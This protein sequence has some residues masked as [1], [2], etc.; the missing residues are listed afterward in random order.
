[1]SE[2]KTLTRRQLD[3]IRELI[4]PGTP[5]RGTPCRVCGFYAW[6]A[7]ATECPVWRG[8]TVRAQN[9]RRAIREILRQGI[10]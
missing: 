8:Q 7:R 1:M 2:P 6:R 5:P 10:G 4:T 3:E 9:T